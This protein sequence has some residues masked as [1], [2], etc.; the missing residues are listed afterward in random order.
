MAFP[1]LSGVNDL[2]GLRGGQAT[3]LKVAVNAS[4]NGLNAI[5]SGV[6]AA[7]GVPPKIVRVLSYVLVCKTAV[8][9]SWESELGTVLAGPMPF[10]ANGGAAPPYNPLG[11]FDTLPGEGLSL[12]L[13]S[14]VQVGGHVTYLIV[15]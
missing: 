7:N 14:G 3:V 8:D 5:V 11:H 12:F 9:V 6:P 2:V 1:T 15:I 4:S 13:S 10:G